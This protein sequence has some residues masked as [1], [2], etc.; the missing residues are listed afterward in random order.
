M[1]SERISNFLKKFHIVLG[2]ETALLAQKLLM[3]KPLKL[4]KQKLAIV[5]FVIGTNLRLSVVT[6]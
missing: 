6:Q 2:L 3:I 5:R 1:L 4:L